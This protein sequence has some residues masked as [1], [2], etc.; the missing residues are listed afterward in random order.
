MN[1]RRWNS[2]NWAFAHACERILLRSRWFRIS[3]NGTLSDPVV[4]SYESEFLQHIE[5]IGWDV[6]ALQRHNENALVADARSVRLVAATNDLRNGIDDV[7]ENQRNLN[8]RGRRPNVPRAQVER[9]PR[10]RPRVRLCRQAMSGPPSHPRPWPG[11]AAGVQSTTRSRP[12]R[13]RN[14]ES[15]EPSFV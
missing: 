3:T 1:K 10:G 7:D 8:R 9:R 5:R 13:R 6:D 11:R 4:Y 12:R 2:A 14:P 15:P